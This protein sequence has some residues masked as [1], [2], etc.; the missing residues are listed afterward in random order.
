MIPAYNS[1]SLAFLMMCFAYKLNKQND[2]K[3]PCYTPSSILNQSVVPYKVLTLLDWYT[4][5]S[6]DR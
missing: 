4:G 1:S 5:F 6:G 2:N 3:Q